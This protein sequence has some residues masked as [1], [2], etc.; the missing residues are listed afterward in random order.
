MKKFAEHNLEKAL[1][2]LNER[3]AFERAGVQFY[4]RILDVMRGSKDDNV[5]QMI[6]QMKKHR[7]Q[8][9]EHEEWLESQIRSLGGDAHKTTEHVALVET[10]SSGIKAIIDGDY[11]LPHLFHALLLAELTDNAGWQLLL[12]LAD[13][14]GDDDAREQFKKRLH[15]EEEHVILMRDAVASFARKEVLGEQAVQFPTS[16]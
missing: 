5:Q 12:D 9:K 13:R 16:P 1:D 10:E 14:A 4:D 6:P 15:H 7:D 11:Q 2:L 8:E 3:L